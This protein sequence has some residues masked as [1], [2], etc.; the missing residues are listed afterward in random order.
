MICNNSKH[1]GDIL[2]LD[3]IGVINDTCKS[4]GIDRL[5]PDN[6]NL[7]D[8]DVWKSIRDDTTL[9]FQ[10]ES[11]SAS[12]FIRQFMSDRTIDIAK[13]RSKN[14]SMLKWMSFGNGLLRPACA[15]FRNSVADG[16]FY[17]NGFPALNDFLAPE[18]GRIAM[19]ETIMRFLV[20]FCGYTDAESDTV[21]RAI[22]K[23]KGTESLLPE[24][25]SRFIDYSSEHYD[26]T[27]EKC[28]EV[29][30]PF[31]QIIL[32]A[33]AYGFS[34]NHS[35]A[36]SCIGY[37]SG[38]LRYYHPLEFLTASLNIFA[39]DTDKT[40]EI[41]A[42]AHKRGIKV[43]NPKWGI[44]RSKY[45]FSEERRI[46]SKG[47]TAVK[48]MSAK[49]ADELYHLA[50]ENE[51]TSFMDLLF[52]IDQK[53]SVNSR[54]IDILIKL[55]FFSDFGNQ[56]E[57]LRMYD[58]FGKVFKRGDAKKINKSQVDGTFLEETIKKYSVGTTKAGA[59]AKSYTI[60]DIRSILRECEA[61]I[62]EL[63]MPDLDDIIKI[64]NFKEYMGY[65]GYQS[66]R[67][68]DRAKLYVL[69][70]YP[71]K[72]K[73]DGFQFG[74]TVVTKSIGS[75]I[76]TRW[77]VRKGVYDKNPIKEND[78][79]LCQQWDRNE[80]GYFTMLKYARCVV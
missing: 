62:R 73:K 18:A 1:N 39:D 23:K 52:D 30:K 33:S 70:V 28:E 5:T 64:Q 2:G 75:G 55:D 66:D 15:S 11:E 34:W 72:R 46:I 8:M 29:I 43:T 22:A 17:D 57:L 60:T 51:Y 3:N 78:I 53:T 67:E 68:S 12:R 9:I 32:D 19:Q 16:E 21:R 63:N 69:G 44:S 49:L 42:Y 4:L 37:I 58:M 41:T 77:T 71:L 45:Y 79:I 20:N 14:F 59:E 7:D 74:Y 56:R 25:E 36:Y 35:D 47:L 10:W 24:I 65:I 48:F 54:Q 61:K 13:K 31:L 80:R 38:Y 26:I 50:S 27:K 76:E 6:V 40:A